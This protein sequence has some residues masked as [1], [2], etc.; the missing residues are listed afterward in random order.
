MSFQPG[1]QVLIKNPGS[2]LG[3]VLRAGST[4]KDLP[5]GE[6]GYMVRITTGD[7]FYLPGDLEP[8]EEEDKTLA[9]YSAEWDAEMARFFEAGQRCLADNSDRVALDE[10]WESGRKLGLI[11]TIS[12]RIKL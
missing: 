10:F 6:C 8:A 9:K 7:Y 2:L 5:D 1:Q 3:I 4:D 11:A 12:N